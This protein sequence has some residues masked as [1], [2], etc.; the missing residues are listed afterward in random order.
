MPSCQCCSCDNILTSQGPILALIS[1]ANGQD[2]IRLSFEDSGRIMGVIKSL[3]PDRPKAVQAET[4]KAACTINISKDIKS[5]TAIDVSGFATDSTQLVFKL[6]R[7][8]TLL[9]ATPVDSFK[10]PLGHGRYDLSLLLKAPVRLYPHQ[11]YY[12]TL[13][14]KSAND[15]LMKAVKLNP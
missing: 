3:K 7:R 12:L 5:I 11:N 13:I 6:E 10:H 1:H 2:N 9:S 8:Q 15:T 14:Y 4:F